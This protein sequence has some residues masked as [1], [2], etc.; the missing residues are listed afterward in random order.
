[1]ANIFK[2]ANAAAKEKQLKEL[3]DA[4]EQS[5]LEKI[6][7]T[8]VNDTTTKNDAKVALKYLAKERLGKL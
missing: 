4:S 1:M 7:Q 5:D 2:T 3:I 8:C 6:I